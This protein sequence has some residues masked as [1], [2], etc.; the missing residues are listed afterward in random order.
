[1]GFIVRL[2]S[3]QPATVRK[4]RSHGRM[5]PVGDGDD[6]S[7][8]RS[9]IGATK[10][11]PFGGQTVLDRAE[12]ARL[13]TPSGAYDMLISAHWGSEGPMLVLNNVREFQRISGFRADDWV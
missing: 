1:M 11:E 7:S 12:P 3:E 13:G 6:P 2:D 8:A 4:G 5:T 10:L 9:M